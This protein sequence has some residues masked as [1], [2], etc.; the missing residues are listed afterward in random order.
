M[1]KYGIISGPYFP[2]FGNIKK[3]INRKKKFNNQEKAKGR[4]HMLALRRSELACVA[5]RL[6]ALTMQISKY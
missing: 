5:G 1:S 3:D 6:R 2:V 4:I